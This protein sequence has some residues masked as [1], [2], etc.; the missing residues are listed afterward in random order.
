MEFL[1]LAEGGGH[2]YN[3]NKMHF[4]LRFINKKLETLRDIFISKKQCT[5]CYIFISKIYRIVY[6]DTKL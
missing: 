2:F 4:P 5:F 1:K 3:N 6:Y